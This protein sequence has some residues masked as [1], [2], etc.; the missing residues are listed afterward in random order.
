MMILIVVL[1]LCSRRICLVPVD[2]RCMLESPF[3]MQLLAWAWIVA[4]G[5]TSIRRCTI[6]AVSCP[7]SS[8]LFHHPLT[9]L[10]GRQAILCTPS[11]CTPL[12]QRLQ[13]NNNNETNEQDR[14]ENN[15]QNMQRLLLCHR[16]FAGENGSQAVWSSR[17]IRYY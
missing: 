7:Q 15:A 14:N 12:Q 16:T 2:G 9:P 10:A 11:I 17:H 8:E 5:K 4:R 3:C 6:T 1:Y 13:D